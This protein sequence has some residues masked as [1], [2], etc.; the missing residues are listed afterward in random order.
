MDEDA[1]E[2]DGGE[3]SVE[4]SPTEFPQNLLRLTPPA[5]PPSRS[6]VVINPRFSPR[7]ELHFG[8]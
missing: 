2:Y 5:E 8:G 4:R 1:H 3:A 7:L 6:A